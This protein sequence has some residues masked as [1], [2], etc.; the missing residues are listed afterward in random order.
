MWKYIKDPIHGYIKINK[1]DEEI[2]DTPSFQRLRN[3]FQMGTSFLTYPGAVHSR[4]E[5]SLGVMSLGVTALEN[6]INNSIS[7]G[8]DYWSEKGIRK[9]ELEKMRRTLRYA[10][11]LHDVGHAPFSHVCEIF[12]EEEVPEIVDELIEKYKIKFIPKQTDA[13]CTEHTRTVLGGK[14]PH[15]LLS[16][17]IVLSKYK[18]PLEDVNVNP[19]D[20]CSIILGQERY[21]I[22]KKYEN[23]YNVLS[24][25]LSSSIDVDKLDYLLR[26]NYMT[27]A[28]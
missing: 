12:F 23:H 21:G 16:C 20:V 11:L 26:D 7:S 25:I 15:E 27:G 14:P 5:H 18:K 9:R 13:T 28:S 8:L 22:P 6:V 1:E 24:N 4:F 17:Y 3:I 2:I 19:L 10:C